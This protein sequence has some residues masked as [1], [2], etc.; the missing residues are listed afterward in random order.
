MGNYKETLS[1][2][3]FGLAKIPLLFLASPSVVGLTK[4]DC[5]IK[6]PLNWLTRNH[7]KSMY[8]GALA[9]GADC[10][11]GLIAMDAIRKSGKKVS[12][13]FK[14]FQAQFLKRAEGDV[15]FL[16]HDGEAI[17]KQVQETILT[18]KRTNRSITITAITPKDSGAEPVAK[19]VLTLSLKCHE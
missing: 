16:C 7:L 18:K 6:I 12:L 11:G 5:E 2:R 13:I 3:L 19:F 17:R 15:H 14:D 1:L 10:A 8:F 4:K 9:M